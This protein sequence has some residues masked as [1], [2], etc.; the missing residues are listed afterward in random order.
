MDTDGGEK[1][2][3]FQPLP[4]RTCA[5]E[6]YKPNIP[7]AQQKLA[8]LGVTVVEVADDDSAHLPFDDDFFDLVINRNGA[9]QPQELHRVMKPGGRFITQQI[10]DQNNR[11]YRP[12]FGLAVE[13]NSPVWNL[14]IAVSGLE[15]AQFEIVE[16]KEELS[17]ARIYDVGAMVYYLK[18]IP[19]TLPDIPDF[20]VERYFDELKATHQIIEKQ[21]YIEIGE[22]RFFIM[23]RKAV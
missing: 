1:L 12:L 2:A 10:S 3:Q 17:S 20:S 21:G 16:Q 9:F 5:T 13:D 22:H 7:I 6:A 11:G 15:S 23:A 4:Q 19:W 18:A 8:P 14:E